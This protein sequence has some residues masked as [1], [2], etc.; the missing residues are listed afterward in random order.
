MVIIIDRIYR[1]FFNK[2]QISYEF[3]FSE[4]YWKFIQFKNK[5]IF[6]IKKIR[7]N[8]NNYIDERKF[9]FSIMEFL[10]SIFLIKFLFTSFVL[11]V[12]ILLSNITF[13]NTIFD[14]PIL[15][16]FIINIDNFLISVYNDPSQLNSLLSSIAEISGVFLGLYFTAITLV[17]GTYSRF[18]DNI[19]DVVLKERVSNFYINIISFVT[20]YSLLLLLFN[21]YNIN[22]G[23]YNIILLIL[24]CIITIFSFIKLGLRFF[25]YF[26]PTN[27][28]TIIERD[29]YKYIYSVIPNHF[30]WNHASFQNHYQKL[31][32]QNI[33]AYNNIINTQFKNKYNSPRIVQFLSNSIFT[34]LTR[35]NIIKYKIPSNSQ[36]F[37]KKYQH[38]NWFTAGY[39][40]IDLSLKTRIS[41]APIEIPDNCWL[42]KQYIK[43]IDNVLINSLKK[44]D[45]MS[46]YIICEKGVYPTNTIIKY[47]GIEETFLIYNEIKNTIIS[48]FILK[49]D[50]NEMANKN[51][52]KELILGLSDSIGFYLIEIWLGFIDSLEGISNKQIEKISKQ[53]I[54]NIFSSD[55]IYK[56]NMPRNAIIEMENIIN[57]LQF[58][59]KIEKK[60]ITT[61]WYI[62]QII[63]LECISFINNFLITYFNELNSTYILTIDKIIANK[64][65]L[66]ASQLSLRA[67]E[68]IEKI[69]FNM[70][71]INKTYLDLST[72]KK[73]DSNRE[74]KIDFDKYYKT[75][76]EIKNKVL[77]QMTEIIKNLFFVDYDSS[78][79][80][81]YGNI[82]SILL[83]ECY[84]ALLE[85]DINKYNNFFPTVTIS[86]LFATEKIKPMVSESDLKTKIIFITDPI[87]DLL[88]LSGY[89]LIYS[90][91]YNV[92]FWNTTVQTWTKITDEKP[93]KKQFL[94]ELINIVNYRDGIFNISP[95]DILRTNWKIQFE[96]ILRD[97]KIIDKDEFYVRSNKRK[98]VH[99][100]ELINVISG[101]DHLRNDATHIFLS[102][103]INKQEYI[104]DVEKSNHVKDFEESLNRFK[105]SE[106]NH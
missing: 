40:D 64:K 103:Y 94:I 7:Y 30:E 59:Y 70:P 19:R 1:W 66:Q 76:I 18:P 8:F 73:T 42:E 11:Y 98:R 54:T 23:I 61:E 50:F 14:I 35:Y 37:Q 58:E 4:K 15:S 62:N 97:M 33:E 89:S 81:M 52:N 105:E 71:L 16:P 78:I 93:N 63:S 49:V 95:K 100:S 67:I 32:I 90:E 28:I 43:I 36:W 88:E 85:K 102:Q 27:L 25:D 53:M 31:T 92:D 45:L 82:H 65:Y 13:Q 106:E 29:I 75:T 91:L 6:N 87:M 72:M 26:E 47:Y 80:D 57:K 60:I 41:L 86:C 56:I 79:P 44:N 104:K 96:T 24:L 20:S 12:L 68:N 38:K 17:I 83:D 3:Q 21:I 22:V 55:S 9:N 34:L 69:L 10:F 74:I 5:I 51:E 77:S 84:K 39:P 46:A 101:L 99:K 48:Y 2:Y